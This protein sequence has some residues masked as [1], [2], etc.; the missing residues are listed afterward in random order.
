MSS[1]STQNQISDD[2]ARIV[3]QETIWTNVVSIIMAS[4]V[5]AIYFIIYFYNKRLV[6]RVTLRLAVANSVADLIYS[7]MMLWGAFIT[8]DGLDCHIFMWGFIEFTIL[9]LFLN[10]AIA[11]NLCAVYVWGV[12]QTQRFEVYYFTVPILLSLAISIPLPAFH[13]FG[14]LEDAKLC[15]F[16]PNGPETLIWLGLTYYLWIVLSVLI[17]LI[18]VALLIHKLKS[19]QKQNLK[20]GEKVTNSLATT[21][22]R[23]DKTVKQVLIRIV[24]YPIV[25]TITQSLS[26]IVYTNAFINGYW[27]FGLMFSW[28]FFTAIQGTLNA[29]VFACDPA[30]QN[31]WKQVK[32]HLRTKY[33]HEINCLETG[34]LARERRMKIWLIRKLLGPAQCA[35]TGF[36]NNNPYFQVL[37]VATNSNSA[38]KSTSKNPQ[39]Q[40]NSETSTSTMQ[41]DPMSSLSHY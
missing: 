14:W 40:S 19:D 27:N 1:Y 4:T 16:V 38:T 39:S 34:E 10:I 6:D 11:T 32:N 25:P 17:L 7:A 23:L 15:W 29:V 24:F 9:P 21:K 36:V 12:Q 26:I 20:L 28:C 33:K 35:Q 18:Q 31:T 22:M 13:R 30:V 8:A 2:Q 41:V 3:A 37:T 5:I